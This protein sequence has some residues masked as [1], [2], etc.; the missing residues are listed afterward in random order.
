[1]TA[2]YFW[3]YILYCENGSYY[4]GYTN[5]LV[6]RFQAHVDGSGGCKYTRSFKPVR[7]AQSWK[8]AGE[9]AYAMHVERFLKTLSRQ[10]KDNFVNQPEL[11]KELFPDII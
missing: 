8:V 3:V 11:L 6:K 10:K 1:M 2:K 5:D 4:I 7:I 9:K